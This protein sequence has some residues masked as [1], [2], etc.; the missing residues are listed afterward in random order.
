MKVS[1]VL[2]CGDVVVM[3]QYVM[4]R[5]SI[6]KG[7]LLQAVQKCHMLLFSLAAHF[8]IQDFGATHYRLCVMLYTF[9]VILQA[10]NVHNMT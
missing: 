8:P 5:W 7:S 6:S 3:I 10:Q 1:C 9:W 2:D 4:G